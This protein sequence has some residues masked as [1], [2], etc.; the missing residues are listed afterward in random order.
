MQS[1][2]VQQAAQMQRKPVFHE[3]LLVLRSRE[4]RERARCSGQQSQ[5]SLSIDSAAGEC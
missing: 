2:I 5:V 4:S 3:Q 1:I